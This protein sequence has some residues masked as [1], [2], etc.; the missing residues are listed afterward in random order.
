MITMSERFAVATMLKFTC[1][2]ALFSMTNIPE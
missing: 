2:E 1:N